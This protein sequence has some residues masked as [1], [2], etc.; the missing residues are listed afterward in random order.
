MHGC[1]ARLPGPNIGPA[2]MSL[3][4]ISDANAIRSAI[5]EFDG[6]GRDPFLQKY[7]FGRARQYFLRTDQGKLYDS[8]AI[9]GAAHGIQF[10]ERGPMRAEDFSGGEQTVKSLLEQLGFSVTGPEPPAG[11]TARSRIRPPTA[12][13]ASARRN[14]CS[15][16][17]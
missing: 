3:S 6:L 15:S 5:A 12:P 10:P 7:G 14:Q 1:L 11:C 17:R 8:K 13:I 16:I 2:I 4:D 9:V